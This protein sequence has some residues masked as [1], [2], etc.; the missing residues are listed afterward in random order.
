MKRE[1]IVVSEEKRNKTFEET[2]GKNI[3]GVLA[4]VLIFAGLTLFATAVSDYISDE[5]KMGIILLVSIIMFVVGILGKNK[6]RN[7]FFMS[8]SG[9]GIGAIFISIFLAYGYFHIISMMVLYIAIGV[10]A[11]AVAFLGGEDST[12]FRIIGQIGI[13]AALI[14]GVTQ[15]YSSNGDG[16]ILWTSVLVIFFIIISMAYL[17]IDHSSGSVSYKVEIITD[18]V[19]TAFLYFSVNGIEEEFVRFALVAVVSIY[20]LTL[21]TV[22]SRK[23]VD[24]FSDNVGWSIVVLV[25]SIIFLVEDV[26][27]RLF[28]W[29]LA[30]LYSVLGIIYVI[31]VLAI[32]ELADQKQYS[33]TPVQIIEFIPAIIM[34]YGLEM[35][36]DFIG[37]GLLVIPLAILAYKTKNKVY[38]YLAVMSTAAF[39]FV[40]SGIFG[41]EQYIATY[42]LFS[43]VFIVLDLFVMALAKDDIY[44][45]F[46]KILIYVCTNFAI[47]FAIAIIADKID[48]SYSIAV[49]WIFYASFILCA[50]GTLSSFCKDWRD[51][52][53]VD[54]ASQIFLYVVNV[55][56]AFSAISILYAENGAVYHLI[57]VIVFAII[58]CLNVKSMSDRFGES[59]TLWV[60]NCIK[61]TLFVLFTM[62]SYDAIGYVVSAGLLA[63]AITCIIYGFIRN[64]KPVRLYGLILSILAIGKIVLFDIEYNSNIARAATIF[65]CGIIAF[66]ICLVYNILDKKLDPVEE[67][68]TTS[69]PAMPVGQIQPVQSMQTMQTV[70]PAQYGQFAQTVRQGQYM[71]QGGPVNSIQSG[72]FVQ[73]TQPEQP[74]Q[75]TESQDEQVISKEQSPVQQPVQAV[76]QTAPVPLYFVQYVVP[77]ANGRPIKQ[78]IP[79]YPGQAMM[80]LDN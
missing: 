5:V 59:K 34:C 6:K 24:S 17:I 64:Y 3:M 47:I 14:F 41:S 22:Y 27:L 21:L 40:N 56:L 50:L 48:A 72:E 67:K 58:L 61:L 55:I 75:A 35:V 79:V 43:L 4:S 29:D 1:G 9:C 76:Q 53:K 44:D 52:S 49:N 12:L 10:W 13:L 65:G 7:T 37:A 36:S 63:V 2:I 57:N 15:L 70:Q 19:A 33:K 42:I 77:D 31:G 39:V 51:I 69:Q 20:G 74:T 73:K 54:S 38:M 32:N 68:A 16:G 62:S 71:Q 45:S 26:I 78:M 46:L 8:L 25:A 23:Y 30:W 66:A 60:Y 80:P 28:T 11:I 18:I